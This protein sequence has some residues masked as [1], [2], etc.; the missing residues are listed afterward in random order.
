M[1]TP[2]ECWLGSFPTPG[3]AA[4]FAAMAEAD[5]RDGV[6]FT[7]SQNLHGD[8]F[9]ALAL[10]A[11]VTTRLK[12]ATGATNPATRLPAVVASSIATVQAESNGRAV[13]GIARGDSALAYLGRRPMPLADFECALAQVQSYLRGEPVDLDGY[14]SRMEWVTRIGQPKVPVSVAATGP[15]VIAVAATLAERVTFSVG[16]DVTRLRQAIPQAREA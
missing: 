11:G 15:R 4:S 1:A 13:L 2:P 16:A 5:G 7:D 9:V 6:A 8:T 14:E 12:L 3:R 10:A